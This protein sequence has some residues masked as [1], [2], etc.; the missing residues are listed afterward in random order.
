MIESKC[1]SC[2]EPIWW[3]KHKTTHKLAPI[4]VKITSSGNVVVFPLSST[5]EIRSHG[6]HMNHFATCPQAKNWHKE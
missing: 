4:E 6:D 2:G 1:R 3:L 5:Y